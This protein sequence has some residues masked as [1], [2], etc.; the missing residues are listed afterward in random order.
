MDYGVQNIFKLKFISINVLVTLCYFDCSF[1]CRF[2]LIS[3]FEQISKLSRN[4]LHYFLIH[5]C[6]VLCL[7][8]IFPHSHFVMG[9]FNRLTGLRRKKTKKKIDLFFLAISPTSE[10]QIV[11]GALF[12]L[13]HPPGSHGG[14][15]LRE[16]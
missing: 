2:V 12:S 4:S 8:I 15:R 13:H 14:G 11:I 7:F 1:Y 16:W 9:Y 6:I 10:A 5:L 3:M